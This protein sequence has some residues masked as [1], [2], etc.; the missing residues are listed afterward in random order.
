MI[1][2]KKKRRKTQ[3]PQYTEYKRIHA[4]IIGDMV[5]YDNSS[6]E[7]DGDEFVSYVIQEYGYDIDDIA[8]Y[9]NVPSTLYY[10]YQDDKGNNHYVVDENKEKIKSELRYED[11]LAYQKYFIDNIMPVYE[12]IIRM[13]GVNPATGKPITDQDKAVTMIYLKDELVK[14]MELIVG[15]EL[16]EKYG[17]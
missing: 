16:F 8:P 9:I 5:R 2:E 11:M 7:T 14:E 10:K 6:N 17:K 3:S 13:Q 12:R 4:H 15:K 1:Y